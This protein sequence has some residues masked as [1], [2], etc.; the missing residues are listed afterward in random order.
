MIQRQENARAGAPPGVIEFKPKTGFAHD[1]S[2]FLRTK[3][4]GTLG[5]AIAVVLILIAVCVKFI[6]P[7][8]GLIADPYKPIVD[9]INVAPSGDAWFGG[10]KIGPDV[11]ARLV[12]GAFMI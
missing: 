5:A 8:V 4:L 2:R 11:F 10:D 7:S 12:N 3:P 1:V 6:E 9:R